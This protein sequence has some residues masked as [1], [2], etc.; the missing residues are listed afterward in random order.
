MMNP[1][2]TPRLSIG[3]P[4][5]N[6]AGMLAAAL[7]SFLAQSFTDFEIVVSDNAS[8]DD[9]PR[10][11]EAYASRDPRLRFV[12]NERNVGANGN[13]LRAAQL[14]RAPLF[15]W[16]AHDDLYEPTYLA[17]CIAALDADAGLVLA[18]ADTAFIDETGKSY[19]PAGKPGLWI[20][21]CGKTLFVA[22][23]VDLATG[24]SPLGRFAHVIFGSLWGTHMFGVVPRQV[25]EKTKLIQNVPN[26]DRPLLAELALLG[27]FSTVP[28]PLFLKRLHPRMSLMLS[29]AQTIAYVS[30]DGEKYH[31]RGRQLGVYLRTPVGKPVGWATRNACRAVVLAYSAQVAARSWSGRRHQAV[32]PIPASDQS[33]QSNSS[34][35]AASP[36]S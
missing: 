30:G 12:R 8:S 25:L 16:A 24:S 10:I 33:K 26:S 27:R 31:K 9:T 17:R 14:S 13:F 34:F 1:R 36:R 2:H 3:I 5:Y 21:P 4:V 18:H 29:D 35:D 19:T 23:P 7:D 28:E 6:G 20:G 22:D 11:L 15:K 32:R